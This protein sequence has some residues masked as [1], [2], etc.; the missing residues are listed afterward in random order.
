VVGTAFESGA[1]AGGA[2]RDEVMVAVVVE[3][4]DP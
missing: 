4:E 2:D 3:E 1:L